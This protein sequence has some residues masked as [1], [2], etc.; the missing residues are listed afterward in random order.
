[1][2]DSSILTGMM[3]CARCKAPIQPSGQEPYRFICV[4]CNQNYLASF[5]LIPVEPLRP[6]ALPVADAEDKDAD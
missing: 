5:S 6:L 4:S 1:M 2:S 3:R